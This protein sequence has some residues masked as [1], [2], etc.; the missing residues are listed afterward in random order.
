[1]SPTGNGLIFMPLTFELPISKQ[2]QQVDVIIHK[3]TDE[4]ISAELSS[5]LEISNN[6]IYSKGM[7][8]L[9]RFATLFS[10]DIFFLLH[11]YCLIF[12]M[13]TLSWS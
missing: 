11:S 3:A 13:H 7:L 8:E 5:S 4:I 6:I 2:L 1:M 12:V 10:V 9:Q